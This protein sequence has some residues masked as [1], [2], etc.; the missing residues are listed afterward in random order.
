M[1]TI[2]SPK[3]YA[4]PGSKAIHDEA[5][6]VLHGIEAS[7]P[8]FATYHLEEIN[9]YEDEDACA[10]SSYQGLAA[11]SPFI[12]SLGGF[13]WK[14]GDRGGTCRDE[15]VRWDAVNG[16]GAE[17]RDFSRLTD[18]LFSGNGISQDFRLGRKLARLSFASAMFAIGG[19]ALARAYAVKAFG[20]PDLALAYFAL[21]AS[22]EDASQSGIYPAIGRNDL[23]AALPPQTVDQLQQ[24]A[25]SWK[26]HVGLGS[27]TEVIGALE[28]FG[29]TH[30]NFT[31]FE[32]QGS[33]PGHSGSRQGTGFVVSA[34]GH[35][36]TNEHVVHGCSDVR[37]VGDSAVLKVVA[38]DESNDLALLSGATGTVRF[39]IRS[40]GPELGE[41]ATALGYPLGQMSNYQLNATTGSVTALAG[42]GGDSRYFQ[43]SAP[44]QPGNSGGPVIDASGGVIGVVAATADARKV[45]E[46]SGALPQNMNYAIQASVLTSF[47]HAHGVGAETSEERPSPLVDVINRSKAGVLVLTCTEGQDGGK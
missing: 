5:R 44:V 37:T 11:G 33:S 21:T 12:A 46:R 19:D 13:N 28:Y 36:I 40:S 47:L 25:H 29:L 10:V 45:L 8:A 42:P 24:R 38:V 34:L 22:G 9:C 20:V 7:D 16:R 32:G 26:E 17:I 2:H 41:V 4:G 23:V 39:K 43:L 27:A 18:C 1:H 6:R 14:V 35:V 15:V 3:S 30:I 31:G